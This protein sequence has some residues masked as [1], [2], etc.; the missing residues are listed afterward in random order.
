MAE[1][2]SNPIERRPA[3]VRELEAAVCVH[4]RACI[5]VINRDNEP[6]YYF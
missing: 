2:L 1:T 3:R 4:A 5:Q 6:D